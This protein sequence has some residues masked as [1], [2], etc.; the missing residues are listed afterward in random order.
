MSGRRGPDRGAGNGAAVRAERSAGCPD[1]GLP[2]AH[3]CRGRQR[4]GA[5]VWSSFRAGGRGLPGVP[6][7]SRD[8]EARARRDQLDAGSARSSVIAAREEIRRL[9]VAARLPETP[10]EEHACIER[11]RRSSL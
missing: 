11:E 1:C 3:Y 7:V 5:S 2:G 4:D 6:D 10:E 8:G 9:Q